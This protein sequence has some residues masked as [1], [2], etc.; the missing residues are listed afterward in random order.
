[1]GSFLV[2]FI[3]LIP[4]IIYFFSIQQLSAGEGLDTGATAGSY[5]GLFF[6]AAV[7]TGIGICASSFTNNAVIA[8]ITALIGCALF[9]YGFNAIS[10]LP[11][12][13]SGADYY[14]D[15]IG[16]DFHYRSISRGLIDTRDVIYFLSIIILFLAITHQNV[17]KK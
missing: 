16:I 10:K 2:V 5:I 12:L 15:M 3:A 11:A 6:L 7:F 8:F 4:S 17:R 1:M 9:Y 14:I 13:G